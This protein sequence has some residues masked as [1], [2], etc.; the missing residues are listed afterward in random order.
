MS[1]YHIVTLPW[2]QCL[3][4]HPAASNIAFDEPIPPSAN[5]P[6]SVQ[7]QQAQPH[8]YILLRD[9][10]AFRRLLVHFLLLTSNQKFQIEVNKRQCTTRRNTL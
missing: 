9:R 5:C 4:V 8:E 3:P 2:L 1:K 6:A 7:V 10:K